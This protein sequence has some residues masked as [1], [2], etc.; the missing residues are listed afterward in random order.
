MFPRLTHYF[1]S[2]A[3][4]DAFDFFA[5]RWGRI[6]FPGEM[7]FWIRY[8]PDDIALRFDTWKRRRALHKIIDTYCPCCYSVIPHFIEKRLEQLLPDLSDRVA[9][10]TATPEKWRDSDTG[11]AETDEW[12][13]EFL[14][15]QIAGDTE[16][17]HAMKLCIRI[18]K[19]INTDWYGS[20]PYDI[21]GSPVEDDWL[22]DGSGEIR[23][24][25]NWEEYRRL[26]EIYEAKEAA[27]TALL[28]RLLAKYG[29]RWWD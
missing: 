25:E 28:Y 4:D 22:N 1:K 7:W 26:E 13:R 29:N 3:I 6:R 9:S 23:R 12:K 8:L 15:N 11:D 16:K 5:L 17:L 10:Y 14:V 27:E 24:T 2:A 21:A 18:L 19:R 20:R